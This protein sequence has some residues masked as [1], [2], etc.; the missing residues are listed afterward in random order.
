[1]ATSD[2]R[3]ANVETCRVHGKGSMA[4]HLRRKANE[5]IENKDFDKY[6]DIQYKLWQLQDHSEDAIKFFERGGVPT[7]KEKVV[8]KMDNFADSVMDTRDKIN[9]AVIDAIEGTDKPKTSSNTEQP[10]LTIGEKMGNAADRVFEVRDEINDTASAAAD[11][12]AD[13][14]SG[15]IPAEVRGSTLTWSE[16]NPFK[17][18]FKNGKLR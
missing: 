14:H 1:M 6:K 5:A 12:I 4:E 16:L 13:R 3:A 2:C 8:E 18:P 17:N 7:F 15:E 10:K 9:K 11:L